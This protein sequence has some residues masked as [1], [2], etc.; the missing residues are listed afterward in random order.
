MSIV[1]NNGLGF[2]ASYSTYGP[3]TDSNGQP[4]GTVA[5]PQHFFDEVTNSYT[6]YTFPSS[7]RNTPLWRCYFTGHSP[8]SVGS[9]PLGSK[10]TDIRTQATF[11]NNGDHWLRAI[12]S[13]ETSFQA[14]WHFSNGEI[15]VNGNDRDFNFGGT[16]TSWS[17]GDVGVS[18]DI[19][20]G[21]AWDFV[22]GDAF[23]TARTYMYVWMVNANYPGTWSPG[24]R[25]FHVTSVS[26]DEPS[27]GSGILL[28]NI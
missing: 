5:D 28:G 13:T 19:S 9:I 2:G 14:A 11:R 24:V 22:A 12:I 8:V 3:R 6:S 10:I 26:Y 20:Q 25:N 18:W 1:Y 7:D 23:I 15:G 27:I 21:L 4:Y 17:F 16:T